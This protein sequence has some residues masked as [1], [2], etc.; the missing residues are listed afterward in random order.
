MLDR[1]T[2]LLPS[3]VSMNRSIYEVA[4][5][6]FDILSTFPGPFQA[7]YYSHIMRSVSYAGVKFVRGVLWL[8]SLDV[9]GAFLGG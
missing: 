5:R 8:D 7:R 4:L 1:S 6:V 3:T 2:H 9:I